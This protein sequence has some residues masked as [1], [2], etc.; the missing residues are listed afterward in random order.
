MQRESELEQ[1]PDREHRGC[2]LNSP[3]GAQEEGKAGGRRRQDLSQKVG[4]G[5]PVW[6]SWLNRLIFAQVLI[7]GL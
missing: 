4:Q 7:S 2:A 3:G 5:A 1:R 6:L